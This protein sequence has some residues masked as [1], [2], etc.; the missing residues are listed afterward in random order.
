MTKRE[1][2]RETRGRLLKAACEVFARKGYRDAKTAEICRRAD[3]NVASV[4][5]YFGGKASLYKEVWHFALKNFETFIFST[6]TDGSPQARLKE[7]IQALMQNLADQG[8]PGRFSRLYLMEMVNPTGLIHDA[9]Q[10]MVEPKRRKIHVIIREIAGP[11]ADDL[12]ILMC[13]LS[14]INQCRALVTIKNS[15]LEYMLDQPLNPELINRL[16]DHVAAFSLGGI[17]AVARKTV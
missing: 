8:E 1:D 13:E 9:W 7:F 16:A 6:A 17:G 10:E 5:Y 14:I 12:T 2:G 11:D 15:D 3:A 4:N